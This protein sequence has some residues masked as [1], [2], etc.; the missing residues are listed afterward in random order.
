MLSFQKTTGIAA[1]LLAFTYIVAFVYF[2]A[3]WSFPHDADAA[4]KM[5]YLAQEQMNLYTV[6]FIIYILFG[7]ILSMLVLGLQIQLEPLKSNFKY[8]VGLFGI[9]WVSLVIA[10]GMIANTGLAHA[11]EM[12]ATDPQSALE[13]HTLF[14]L[15]ANSIGGGN[16]IVGGLWVVIF[17]TLALKANVMH[18][19]LHYLGLFVG[20]VGILTVYPASILTEIFGVSQ[21]IWFLYLGIAI[22]KLKPTIQDE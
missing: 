7:C 8:L 13:T 15:I 20:W 16:E 18:R 22:L 11:I 4:T 2:G 5:A 10:S 6:T 21:I 17:S 14:A 19:N 1:I 12:S 3:F 9:V